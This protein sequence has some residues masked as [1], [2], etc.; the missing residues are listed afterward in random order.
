[1]SSPRLSVATPTDLEIVLTR[2][3]NAPRDLVWE[4]TSKPELIQQWL[5]GPPGWTMTKCEGFASW[6]EV[7]LGVERS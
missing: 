4:A 7:S 5:F 2:C 1:M 6:W 3:F